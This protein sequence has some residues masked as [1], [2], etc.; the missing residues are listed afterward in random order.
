MKDTEDISMC[1][2]IGLIDF[3]NYYRGDRDV[4]VFCGLVAG[5]EEVDMQ[6]S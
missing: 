4:S 5:E 3:S 6:R 2:A 1:R